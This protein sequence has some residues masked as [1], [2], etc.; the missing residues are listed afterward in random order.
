[1]DS[2]LVSVR[3]LVTDTSC[4]ALVSVRVLVTDTSC[5]ALVSVRVL[6]TE[7]WYSCTGCGSPGQEFHCASTKDVSRCLQYS[8]HSDVGPVLEDFERIPS[9]SHG[10]ETQRP[11]A[12]NDAPV[13]NA[14]CVHVVLALHP[15]QSR[16]PKVPGRTRTVAVRKKK[17]ENVR[18]KCDQFLW[19]QHHLLV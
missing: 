3:V 1:M 11:W 15:G 13:S 5:D 4:C 6:V 17:S 12:F 16:S 19:F 9:C 7:T 8:R 14:I 18:W 2:S 10:L